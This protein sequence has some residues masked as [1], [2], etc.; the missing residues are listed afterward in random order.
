MCGQ[1]L[2]LIF[3]ALNFTDAVRYAV[4]GSAEV[5][6]PLA[7]GLKGGEQQPKVARADP[8]RGVVHR[9][10]ERDA[11]LILAKHMGKLLPQGHRP[12]P[13]NQFHGLYQVQPGA[14]AGAE[15]LDACDQ[16][17]FQFFQASPGQDFH[18]PGRQHDPHGA[19]QYHTYD[20][21]GKRVTNKAEHRDHQD[22]NH[23]HR[24]RLEVHQKPPA[25]CPVVAV[26]LPGDHRLYGSPAVPGGHGGSRKYH[27]ARSDLPRP[28]CQRLLCLGEYHV[29]TSTPR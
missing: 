18:R 1:R 29:K 10:I 5:P 4:Q 8:H 21:P 2:D 22:G 25:K 26:L 3:Q 6:A 11:V 13:G 14:D 9:L 12:V 7:V 23:R 15:G 17:S 19:T 16:L 27:H 24:P 28:V 20:I